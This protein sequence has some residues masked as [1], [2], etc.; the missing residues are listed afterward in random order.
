ME[1]L[2]KHYKQHLHTRKH[3]QSYL[4]NINNII[5][6]L[7]FTWAL[8]IYISQISSL[9]T[10][11]LAIHPNKQKNICSSSRKVPKCHQYSS[12]SFVV[13][14]FLHPFPSLL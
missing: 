4:L 5:T 1:S 14:Y 8:S 2:H 6:L 13:W 3:T 10:H 9:T 7:H 11:I 12:T